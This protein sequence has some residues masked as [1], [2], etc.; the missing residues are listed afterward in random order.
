[1]DRA[2]A[3]AKAA[4]PAWAALTV[5]ERSKCFK[6]LAA[7]VRE[8]NDEL[9]RLEALSMGKP[10]STYI[11]GHAFSFMFDYYSEAGYNIQGTSSLNTPGFVNLTFRQPYGV[12]AVIIPWNVPLLFFAK[13]V[14]PAL[15]VGNTVVLKS[16]EKAPLAASITYPTR[17]R[18]LTPISLLKLATSS[19]KQ[20]FH[21][22]SST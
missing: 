9:A 1:V 18:L 5:E 20:D 6:K 19:R 11:D 15:A 2:V 22:E 10:V 13:K 3:A 17:E 4:Q 8:H 12:V 7:L 16:S 14:A 21:L